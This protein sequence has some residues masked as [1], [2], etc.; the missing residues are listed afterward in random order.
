MYSLTKI[1]N[2]IVLNLFKWLCFQDLKH[3][4]FSNSQTLDHIKTCMRRDVD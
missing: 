4:N 3:D 1:K 2:L